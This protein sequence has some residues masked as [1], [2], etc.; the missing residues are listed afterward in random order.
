MH[1]ESEI[2]DN[3]NS[4]QIIVSVIIPTKNSEKYLEKCLK[5]IKNQTFTDF[6]IIIVDNF[7]T[8][9]TPEIAQKYTD[10]FFQQGPERS[11]QR[12]FGVKKANG[13]FLFF[14]DSD[15]ELSPNLLLEISH[16]FNQ[17]P[18]LILVIPEYVPGNTIYT[19]AKNLEK[20]IY[21]NND[22]IEAARVFSKYLFD[23]IGG[24]NENMIAG[25]DWDLDRRIEKVGGQKIRTK[26]IIHHNEEDLGF[27]KS[28]QKKMYYAK[29][30][31]GYKVGIQSEVNPLYRLFVF[32]SKPFLILKHPI[33]FVYLILL[34]YTEFA[35]G[36][37]V[38]KFK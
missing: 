27:F 3:P 6:E 20:R 32:F 7:S 26:A 1:Q 2:K 14:V 13:K 33:S 28:I 35:C 8:D 19:K 15:M 17:K 37:L 16:K 24:F 22:K 9:K 36:F 29:K 38:Y 30:L 18:N 5:S 4:K 23:K 21:D 31:T 10:K 34:R 25:E 11:A 12:N